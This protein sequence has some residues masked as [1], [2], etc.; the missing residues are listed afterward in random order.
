MIYASQC[1]LQHYL[2]QLEHW[3]QPKIGMFL[4]ATPTPAWLARIYVYKC[5]GATQIYFTKSKL[6]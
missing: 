4:E 5:L 6:N 2:Q 3:K 1:E